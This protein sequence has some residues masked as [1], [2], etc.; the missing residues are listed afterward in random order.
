M[1]E[2]WQV[3]RRERPDVLHTHNPKPGVYGRILGRLAGVPIIVNTVHGLYAT[4]DDRVG[5]RLLVYILEALASR[6]SD[7]ELVQSPEDLDLLRRWRISPPS[8][9]SLLGNGVDLQRFDCSS[10]DPNRRREL[11]ADLGVEDDQILIGM[12]GRLV[13]EKGYL[14]LFE[15]F[16]G[17]DERYRLVVV[18]PMDADKAD[19]LGSNV[20]EDA[21]AAGVQFLG[22]RS[23][24]VELYAAMDVFVLPSHREGF[25]RAAMEAA[26]MGLPVIATDIRGCRQV[27]DPGHNGVL[28]PVRDPAALATAIVHLGSDP[29]L[30]R[31]M[32][33]ASIAKSRGEF[34]ERHV[35]SKV[36][37]AY[38]TVADRK[39]LPWLL[40]GSVDDAPLRPARR[41]DAG[42]IASLHRRSIDTG[43]LARLGTP[44]LSLLYAVMIDWPGAVV[45]V[46]Q[47]AEGTP[48]GFV[49]GVDDTTAFYRHFLRT[50]WWRAVPRVVPRLFTPSLA[51]RAWETLRYGTAGQDS[52]DGAELLSMAVA[53]VARGRG[54]GKQLGTSF[55]ET[56]RSRGVEAVKV[57][58]GSDNR[59][60]I[61]AYESMGFAGGRPTEIH[62]GETSVELTWR[63]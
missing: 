54:W 16:R 48:L 61:A 43:F 14:E 28:V 39:G 29:D 51:R 25:P 6:F 8:R 59:V 26:A 23:D 10:I 1:K 40:A 42:V 18:G 24:M 20:V 46:A 7:A 55:L 50:Q 52:S 33:E 34:D 60:A 36:M 41:S 58:V 38:R 9:T 5:K 27:V 62:A 15:A 22:M 12:V 37:A 11:R 30:R 17:L 35:V 45:L 19:G 47:G 56:M 49:A 32:G 4:E 13:A 57:V 53:P 31:A 44:F 2:F 63:A 3:V 21:R